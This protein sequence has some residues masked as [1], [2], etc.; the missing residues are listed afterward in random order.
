MLE[1]AVAAVK[2]DKPA[3]LKAFTAD[4][5][6]FK[7]RDLYVFCGGP[8]GKTSAHGANP[9]R[10]GTAFCEVVDKA[11]KNFG[12]ELCMAKEGEFSV[13]EYVWPRPGDRARAEGV[14]CD[15]DR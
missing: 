1:R 9:A 10:I 15:Q 2:A 3:A 5:D 4:A 8:D 7:D 12:A 14:L 6:G 13:V 11:G